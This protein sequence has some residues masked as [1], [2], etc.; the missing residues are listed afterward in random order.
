MAAETKA[1]KLAR[2]SGG[3]VAQAPIPE[4]PALPAFLKQRHPD[5]IEAI[6]KW[7][8]DCVEFFKKAGTIANG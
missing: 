4:W 7:H 3:V 8:S 5:Q 6:D 2:I 1:Q